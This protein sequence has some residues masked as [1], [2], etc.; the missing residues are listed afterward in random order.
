MK[1]FLGFFISLFFICATTSPNLPGI[2]DDCL[3][4]A[5]KKSLVVAR[6]VS[7]KNFLK[8]VSLLPAIKLSSAFAGHVSSFTEVSLQLRSFP[9]D[10]LSGFAASGAGIFRYLAS[11]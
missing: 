8:K 1:I 2:G 3:K 4:K 6:V 11:L 7:C 10:L 5:P 9:Q